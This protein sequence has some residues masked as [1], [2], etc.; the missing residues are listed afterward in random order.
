MKLEEKVLQQLQEDL[1]K[2]KTMD[3]LLGKDGAIKKLIKNAV[4]QMLQ[5]EMTE[6]LG[7]E[8]YAP[9]GRNTGN[10][11]NG[12]SPKN[13]KSDFGKIE[14]EVPRDRNGEFDPT[15]VKKNQTDLGFLDEKI[16]SMYARG[17]TVRDIQAHLQD[18]YGIEV[19]P[20][21][22]SKVT[23]KILS[24]V[25]EWQ[26]RPLSE[27]YPII[28]LD[29]I[30]YKVRDNGRV[31]S[32]AA[33]TCLGI[34]QN[35]MKDFLG[36]WIG[37]SEGSNF[38]LSVLTELKNRGVR[39]ILIACVDGLKGFPEAITTVF[40]GAEVQ[41]CIIHQIRNSL[42]YIA[43]KNQKE[44]M[45]DLKK[46]YTAPTEAKAEHELNGLAD[47]WGQKYPLVINS[48]KRN[49]PNLSTYYKYPPEIRTIIYTTNAVENLHRQFRKVTKTRSAFPHDDALRKLVYLAYRDVSK[50][51][52]MPLRNWSTI[53]SHL[54]LFFEGRLVLGLA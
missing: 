4:E 36:L 44:F 7:Y 34:D 2:C 13:L 6:H 42:R 35:G 14:I 32:K 25:E 38:W 48:W 12:V 19:S 24:L 27:V 40:P 21:F 15:V 33:Y 16:I 50:K 49:W 41:L 18:I 51:W 37:E 3:D 8:K 39:D 1:K 23:E 17:M 22:I 43:S 10:S 52:T 11:R 30:H 5:F 46:V 26:A 53:I 45:T 29:A 31:V 47:K 20:T 54:S 9:E 28:F